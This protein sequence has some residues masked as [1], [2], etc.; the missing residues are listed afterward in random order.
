MQEPQ[1]IVRIGHLD[2]GDARAHVKHSYHNN[3]KNT[4]PKPK[5]K[6]RVS[7]QQHSG[8]RVLL[9]LCLSLWVQ[10]R[11]L[12][13]GPLFRGHCWRVFSHSPWPAASP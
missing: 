10:T 7:L 13:E 4:K 12:P 2:V 5:P 6:P 11:L 1:P 3:N 9:A 8:G